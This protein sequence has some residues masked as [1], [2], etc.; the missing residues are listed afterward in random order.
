MRRSDRLSPAAG[1]QFSLSLL[2]LQR[3]K[4]AVQFIELLH[5]FT[6]IYGPV[7]KAIRFEL[8]MQTKHTHQSF[9]LRLNWH[10]TP[11]T[12]YVVVSS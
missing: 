12:V 2:T 5:T 9:L 7:C 8:L 6:F 11:P 1:A 10:T 4:L 3:E